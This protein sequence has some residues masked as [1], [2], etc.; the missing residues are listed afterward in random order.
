MALEEEEA[1]W[2]DVDEDEWESIYAVETQHIQ[3][4]TYS[5]VLRGKDTH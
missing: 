5:E 1:E 3:Q 4:R 2:P